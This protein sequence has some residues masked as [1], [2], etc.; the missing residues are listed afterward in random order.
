MKLSTLSPHTVEKIKAYRWDRI[1]EKHEGPEDWDSVLEFY[2]PEFMVINGYD[3][4]LP[5]EQARH[6]NITILRCIPGK[7]EQVLTL[8]LKDTTYMDDPELE[9]FYTGFVAVCEKVAGEEFFIATL[10]HEWFI[11]QNP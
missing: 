5:V 2:Q 4:L 11:I 6:P 7:D 3:V 8:F 1:I 9:A 10:Y